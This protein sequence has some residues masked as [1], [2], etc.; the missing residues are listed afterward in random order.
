MKRDHQVSDS[1][2]ELFD[3]YDCVR[4]VMKHLSITAITDSTG[5][6]GKSYRY[7]YIRK[8]MRPSVETHL[9]PGENG[10]LNIG[11][12]REKRAERNG[13]LYRVPMSHARLTPLTSSSKIVAGSCI[14]Y[15]YFT[16]RRCK[17]L[18]FT[19]RSL[20]RYPPLLNS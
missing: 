6:I 16:N 4:M 20:R 10:S 3:I 18:G 7:Q 8:I 11:P 15:F 5:I 9:E 2:F 14:H 19:S 1:R 17:P 13:S 12:F